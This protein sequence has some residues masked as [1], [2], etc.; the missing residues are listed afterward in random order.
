MLT[1]TL[2]RLPREEL[3]PNGDNIRTASEWQDVGQ[4]FGYGPNGAKRM[5]KRHALSNGGWSMILWNSGNVTFY[6]IGADDLTR[7]RFKS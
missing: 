5:A 6:T 4:Q 7:I 3:T 2:P 1:I